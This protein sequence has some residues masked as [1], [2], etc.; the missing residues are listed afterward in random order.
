MEL[1]YPLFKKIWEEVQVS[2][3]WKEGYLIK[4][5]TK[6]DLGSCSNHRGI[7]LLSIQGK[8]SSRVLLK[9]MKD[10]FDPQLRD[11]QAGFRRGRSRTNQIATLRIIL[12]QSCEWNS[13]LCVNFIDYEK[14][15]GCLDRASG[16]C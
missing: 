8:V 4:L 10:A 5:P 7:T 16:N 9:R 12:E 2:S 14:A 1:L 13:P 11:H 6:G 3:E 15:F